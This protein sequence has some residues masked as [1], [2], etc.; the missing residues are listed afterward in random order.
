MGLENRDLR[1][2]P[3]HR[4]GLVQMRTRIMN[5]LRALAMNEGHRLKKKLFSKHGRV[6][7]EK[8]CDARHISDNA[9][10]NKGCEGLEFLGNKLAW[11]T[12]VIRNVVRIDWNG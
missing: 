8:F 4:H 1:Q 9:P 5:Q 6:Q 12:P 11:V 10:Q 3:W 2:L 7:L